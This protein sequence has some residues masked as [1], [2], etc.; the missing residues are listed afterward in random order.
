MNGWRGHEPD[1]VRDRGLCR[2]A[3]WHRRSHALGLGGEG[4]AQFGAELDALVRLGKP[5]LVSEFGTDTLPGCHAADPEM[6]TEEYQADFIAAYLDEMATRPHVCGAHVWNFADFKTTQS[7][8]RAGGLNH[9][10]VFNRC[11]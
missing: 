7:I 3:G 8:L 9:K 10:G 11:P 6:W 4:A 1:G 2:D 5:V